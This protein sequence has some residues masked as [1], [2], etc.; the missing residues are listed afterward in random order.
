MNP[1]RHALALSVSLAFAVGGCAN[2]PPSSDGT[3]DALTNASVDSIFTSLESKDCTLVSSSS[4]GTGSALQKCQGIGDYE[5]FVQSGDGRSGVV[6]GHG[7]QQKP[8]WLLGQ[9][10]GGAF[11][12]L[13][14]KAD[15]RV[16]GP[17]RTPH[18]VFF[19]YLTSPGDNVLVVVALTPEAQCVVDIIDARKH[20]DAN[21]LARASAD[22]TRS[23]PV[24]CPATLPAPR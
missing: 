3:D 5:L 7:G 11:N 13:G 16:H 1:V 9:M 21:L 23:G 19:R 10:L 14:A 4:E 6:I 22:A 2:D 12:D 8:L 24:V 20:P 17:G 15:W 18:A